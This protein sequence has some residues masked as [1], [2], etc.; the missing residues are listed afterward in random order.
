MPSRATAV[1]N[2]RILPGDTVA[3]VI[4]HTKDVVDDPR[5]KMQ[6]IAGEPP[7]E[8]S[9]QS[10]ADSPDFR[11]MQK[12]LAEIYPGAVVAP[13]VFVAA[14]DSKH[15]ASLTENIY[16]FAPLVLDSV[17]VGR[18]HGTNERISVDNLTRSVDFYI[19]LIRNAAGQPAQSAAG[20]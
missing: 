10:P 11:L 18:I 5:V 16:R 19:Q 17:D 8:P 14:T 2:F 3:S 13:F 15:Y 20:N 1:V 6:P 4:E 12:T 7:S 9:A